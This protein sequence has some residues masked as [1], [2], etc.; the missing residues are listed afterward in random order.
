M[1]FPLQS[2]HKT[3]L[4][5]KLSSLLSMELKKEE[6]LIALTMACAGLVSNLASQERSQGS[7]W[8]I[9]KVAQTLSPKS[10]SSTQQMALLSVASINAILC[11]SKTTAIFSK[12]LFWQRKCMFTSPNTRVTPSSE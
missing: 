1:I 2:S 9:I 10:R 3:R 6:F 11:R 5:A 7:V 8:S 12:L 4:L